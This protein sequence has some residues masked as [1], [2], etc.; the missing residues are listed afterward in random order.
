[1]STQLC[2]G[3]D[4]CLCLAM[5]WATSCREHGWSYNG[6]TVP[7]IDSS[8]SPVVGIEVKFIALC[9]SSLAPSGLELYF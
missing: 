1:M 3:V 7:G 4:S 6:T 9:S 2:N 8:I 5:D